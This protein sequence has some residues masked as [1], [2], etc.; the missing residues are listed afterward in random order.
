MVRESWIWSARWK[1]LTG[2]KGLLETVTTKCISTGTGS[3]RWR[4]CVR[5]KEL[6]RWNDRRQIKCGQMNRL[7]FL[8]KW[9]P[10]SFSRLRRLSAWRCPHLLLSARSCIMAPAARH[11]QHGVCNARSI[12]PARKALT[13]LSSKPA[14]R[15]CCCGSMGRTNGQTDGRT[16]ARPLRRPSS[17]YYADSV[18]K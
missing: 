6:Q 15:R 10:Y 1:V 11:P 13:P 2:P 5:Y 12:S 4:E 18:N 9:V 8:Q 16:D 17:A 14:G 7:L 3:E